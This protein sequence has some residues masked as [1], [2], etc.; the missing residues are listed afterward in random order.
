MSHPRRK[1]KIDRIEPTSENLT[2]RA[3]LTPWVRYLERIKVHP[4]FAYLGARMWTRPTFSRYKDRL[5]DKMEVKPCPH[6]YCTT[7]LGYAAISTR[8]PNINREGYCF[9]FGTITSGCD[10][11]SVTLG[12]QYAEG[13]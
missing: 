6:R 11:R 5:I 2:G 1:N 9:V 3:G 12:G 7:H 4:E 13:V 10:V 8:Q